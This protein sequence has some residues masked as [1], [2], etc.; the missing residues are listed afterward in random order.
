[1]GLSLQ[2]RFAPADICFG[3]GQ[4][5]LHGMRLESFPDGDVVRAEWRPAPQYQAFP[6]ILNGGVIG[7]L[8]DCHMNW[9]AAW[10][11]AVRDG[12]AAPPCTV[13][14]EFTIR[15]Q[16]PT[17]ID[18][19]V[20]L[21]AWLVRSSGRRAEVQGEMSHAGV[22]TATCG[23]IFVAVKPEHPAFIQRHPSSEGNL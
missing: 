15:L 6:G 7:T 10:G 17:P 11:L 1:M 14:A 20:R 13:T 2:R 21:S 12:L 8:L 4:A 22:V 9:T 18:G 23:G 5:N 16:A 3:C 19:A